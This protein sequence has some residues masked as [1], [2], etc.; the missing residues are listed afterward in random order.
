[1]TFDGFYKTVEEH[2]S[3][4]G[5]EITEGGFSVRHIDTDIVTF[6]PVEVIEESEWERIEPVLTL[7]QEGEAL[8]YMT[9]VVGYYSSVSNWNES[10]LG[11][12][13]DRK[14]GMYYVD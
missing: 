5:I 10:K 13:E 6:V 12:L 1:M 9:R 7:E 8:K 2:D 14:K 3:L 4:E 11:E